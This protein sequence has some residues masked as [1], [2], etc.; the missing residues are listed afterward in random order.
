MLVLSEKIGFRHDALE[1]ETP[2][3][4]ELPFDYQK[5]SCHHSSSGRQKFSYY[6]RRAGGSA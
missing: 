6:R 4:F 2:K 3:I 5:V 1:Q